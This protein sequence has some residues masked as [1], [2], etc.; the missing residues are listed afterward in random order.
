MP[1]EGT[2]GEMVGMGWK[3]TDNMFT[4]FLQE[5]SQDVGREFMANAGDHTSYLGQYLNNQSMQNWGK[6]TQEYWRGGQ[7]DNFKNA[8]EG[9]K[10]AH[11]LAYDPV[12]LLAFTAPRLILTAKKFRKA[13]QALNTRSIAAMQGWNVQADVRDIALA[14]LAANAPDLGNVAP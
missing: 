6:N 5:Y 11:S 10:L 8:S 12:N 1:R 14:D 7:S 9:N 3:P 2:S 13:G 4:G